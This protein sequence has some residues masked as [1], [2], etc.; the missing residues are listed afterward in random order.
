MAE[1]KSEEQ[2]KAYRDKVRDA[3]R[4]LEERIGT[5]ANIPV[6]ESQAA[7]LEYE[8]AVAAAREEFDKAA[9]T[10]P[11]EGD[12]KAAKATSPT[13]GGGTSASQASNPVRR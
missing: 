9:S 4:R 5:G 8:Q 6:S 11:A 12:D 1:E 13:P 3:E 7:R 2:V 10:A